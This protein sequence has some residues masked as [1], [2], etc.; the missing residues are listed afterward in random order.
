MRR[1]K[2]SYEIVTHESAAE[3]DA[4][5][6]GWIDEEGVEITPDEYD[7]DDS[8]G[9]ELAAVVKLATKTIGGCVE[10]SDY[11]RCHPGHTWYTDSDG[12]T[13]YQTG[14]NTRQSYHLEGFSPDEELAIYAALVGKVRQ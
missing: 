4:A 10:A 6:R 9:D 13:D 2:I 5:E 12:T 14:D 11:P 7:L 8:E 1:I 3:G